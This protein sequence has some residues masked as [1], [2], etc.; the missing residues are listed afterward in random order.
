MAQF[1][2]TQFN[3]PDSLADHVKRSAS[4]IPDW[5]HAN[6]D[7]LADS[8]WVGGD[9]LKLEPYGY[10][11]WNARKGTLMLRNPDDQPH[12]FTLDVGAAFELPSGAATKYAFKSPWAEDAQKPTLAAE[13]GKTGTIMDVEHVVILM[14]ENR[15]F[16]HYFGMLRGVA[17]AP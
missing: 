17:C 5:A 12:D 3:L 6:A 7:V 9:P 13:A 15:S 2:S 11:A 14:Q 1:A 16:D 4:K 8:H 10:A